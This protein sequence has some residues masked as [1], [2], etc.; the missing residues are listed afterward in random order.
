MFAWAT[1]QVC[2]CTLLYL[3]DVHMLTWLS[4]LSWDLPHPCRLA[5]ESGVSA[6]PCHPHWASSALHAHCCGLC[7]IRMMLLCCSWCSL[8]VYGGQKWWWPLTKSFFW[9]G[10]WAITSSG[11]VHTLT[12]RSEHLVLTCNVVWIHSTFSAKDCSSSAFVTASKLLWRHF[13]FKAQANFLGKP[14]VH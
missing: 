8:P 6:D 13:N 12:K 4:S 11:C 9:D 3:P 7:L 10:Y 5:Q 1:L 14:Q 2:W